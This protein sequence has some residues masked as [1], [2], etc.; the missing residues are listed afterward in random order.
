MVPTRQVSNG[1]GG[2]AWVYVPLTTADLY[3]EKSNIEGLP[4]SPWEFRTL[5]R[6]IF[7]THNLTWPDMQTLMATLLMVE[8]KSIIMAKAKEEADKM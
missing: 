5:I 3:N 8:K 2:F 7:F 6:G 1:E 4:V